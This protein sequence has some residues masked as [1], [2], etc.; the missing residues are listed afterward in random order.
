MECEYDSTLK[1]RFDINNEEYIK[2][3]LNW[4]NIDNFY[5][6]LYECGLYDLYINNEKGKRINNDIKIKL[7]KTCEDHMRQKF[8]KCS[9]LNYNWFLFK[10]IKY[11]IDRD[12]DP[13]L[14]CYVY[15]DYENSSF[16]Y[17]FNNNDN[18]NIDYSLNERQKYLSNYD[19]LVVPKHNILYE[20]LNN[21]VY[22]KIGFETY[23][24][25]LLKNMT[26]SLN[27]HFRTRCRNFED[28]ETQMKYYNSK[29][30]KLEC[31]FKF[32]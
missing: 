20:L 12:K 14:F 10:S 3:V 30:N 29:I 5:G 8:I 31:I 6:A 18:Y 2:E 4:K 26:S 24:G 13:E 27:E 19:T 1:D 16:Q 22:I 25:V 9:I 17:P 21:I 23:G 15:F 7:L 28:Y 32:C 11:M